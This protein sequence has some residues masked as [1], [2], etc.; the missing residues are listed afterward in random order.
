MYES[1][2]S[3]DEVN[4]VNDLDN[5]FNFVQANDPDSHY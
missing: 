5:E 3:G 4:G 1:S 2:S